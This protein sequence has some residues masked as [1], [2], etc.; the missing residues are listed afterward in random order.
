MADIKTINDNPIVVGT[1][2]IEDGAVTMAKLASNVQIPQPTDAQVEDAVTTWLTEHPEATTTVQ[3]GSIT[4]AKLMQTGG[5]LSAVETFELNSTNYDFGFMLGEVTQSG[6]TFSTAD[7][8]FRMRSYYV[9]VYK[10]DVFTV[11]NA[12][13]IL[14]VHL[15]DYAGNYVAQLSSAWTNRITVPSDGLA[16]AL[17]RKTS[18]ANITKAEVAEIGANLRLITGGAAREMRFRRFVEQNGLLDTVTWDSR[19]Y[20][21]GNATWST[22]FS[23]AAIQSIITVKD[24]VLVTV[25]DGYNIAY[26]LYSGQNIDI[27]EM[28][29]ASNWLSGETFIPAGSNL[30]LIAKKSDNDRFKAYEMHDKVTIDAFKAADYGKAADVTWTKGTTSADGTINTDLNGATSPV[31]ALTKRVQLSNKCRAVMLLYKGSAY[32]GKLNASG[33]ID[34]QAG[35]WR[36]FTDNIDVKPLLEEFGADSMRICLMPTDSTALT[37]A[38]VQTYGDNN[39]IVVTEKFVPTENYVSLQGGNGS[40]TGADFI[41]REV[42][43][44]GLGT[45]EL[46]QGFCVYNGKYYS[47]DGSSIAVQDASFATEQTV[48]LNLGHGNSLQLGSNGMA[49]ASGWNDDTVYAVD[50]STLTI[51]STISLPTMGYTTAA[52]DDANGI[53]Y[54]FQRDSYPGT[55][56]T[57]NL[58]TYDY[59]NGNVISTRKIKSFAAMRAC[60]YYEGRII[61]AYGLGTSAAPSGM[62]VCNTNGDILAEYDLDIFASTEPEGVC[63]DRDTHE[64]LVSTVG[65]SLY[66]IENV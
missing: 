21:Q 49:Y 15:F 6:V 23:R 64:L 52:I 8:F 50:L 14:S 16:V 53:A 19:Y 17:M 31:I 32:L 59:V 55:V 27:N 60:D 24:D 33:G 20:N 22:D 57:Y 35:N 1:S 36:Y 10:G 63:F 56:A 41:R 4:D 28:V 12:G 54:I 58:I 7:S 43:T 45:L 44:T 5:I 62:F 46:L 40:V 30:Y 9:P 18:N 3:D 47:T 11:G 66:K 42:K 26:G 13:N 51:S 37:D 29:A 39:C 25:V 2:G 34:K 61:V 65:R 48:A 38:T